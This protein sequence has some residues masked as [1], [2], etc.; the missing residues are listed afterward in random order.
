MGID[1]IDTHRRYIGV[2]YFLM[3]LGLLTVIMALFAYLLARKVAYAPQAEV[4]LQAHG[5]WIM[6][7]TA[8]AFLMGVFASLWFIPLIFVYWSSALWATATTVLGVIFALIA[9]LYLLNAWLKGLG[10]FFMKKAVF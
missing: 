1:Q 3:F 6:R 8:L 9:W 5:L 7:S 2:A 10:R 4:W